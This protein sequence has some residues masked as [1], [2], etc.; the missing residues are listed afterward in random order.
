MKVTLDESELYTVLSEWAVTHLGTLFE[1]PEIKVLQ[2]ESGT[3]ATIENNEPTDI[4]EAPAGP[5]G[6]STE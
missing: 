1:K 5:A 6:D 2:D 3:F 4:P